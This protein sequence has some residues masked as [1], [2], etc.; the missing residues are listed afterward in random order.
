MEEREGERVIKVA[1]GSTSKIKQAAVR[2]G[3]SALLPNTSVEVVSVAAASEINE[4]PVGTEETLLG[5]KNRL[6][7]TKAASK[8]K[9][10]DFFVAVENGIYAVPVALS[11]QEGQVWM[12]VGW[13]IVEDKA[14]NSGI[15]VSTGLQ[16]PTEF[17]LEAQEKGFAST[18]V[19]DTLAS[20]L[21]GDAKDP[22]SELTQGQ[23]PRKDL[24][25]PAVTSAL[26]SLLY[27]RKTTTTKSS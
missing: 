24:L 6:E 12:D 3:F 16:I 23:L 27:K 25:V 20:R 13:I 21:G 10:F 5:C 14:G 7:N 18:T 17:V 1:L 8:D 9:I 15:A 26:A 22:H 2:E 11:G 4:Q 19:G